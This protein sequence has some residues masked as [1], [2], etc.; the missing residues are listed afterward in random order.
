[1]DKDRLRL[2]LEI[3][4]NWVRDILYPKAGV[5]LDIEKQSFMDAI[6]ALVDAID[7]FKDYL[8]CNE[9]SG[10]ANEANDYIVLRCAK[11]TIDRFNNIKKAYYADP[12]PSLPPA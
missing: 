5:G 11:L 1:M 4:D 3:C 10:I 2:N 7:K 12:I 9:L 8:L 6:S